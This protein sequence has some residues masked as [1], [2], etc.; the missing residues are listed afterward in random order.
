MTLTH[1]IEYI[2]THM[3][4]TDISKLNKEQLQALGKSIDEYEI[5]QEVYDEARDEDIDELIDA[6]GYTTN[7]SLFS[8][9]L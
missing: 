8:T 6:L 5:P 7:T 3:S 4:K 2:S 1:N 9:F